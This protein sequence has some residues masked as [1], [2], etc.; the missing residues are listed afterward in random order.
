[1]REGAREPQSRH[2]RLRPGRDQTNALDRRDRVDDLLR[3]LEL[4]L[5][6]RAERR[7]GER[8]FSYRLDRL[9]IGVPENE[10]PPRLDPVDELASVGGAD[11]CA[12]P[13]DREERLLGPPPAPPAP[14]GGD[15]PP[16]QAERPGPQRR[17]RQNPEA[18]SFA[19]E[20]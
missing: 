17:P 9:G 19:P 11:V 10:R 5:G 13:A 20:L 2:G 8:S 6:R 1:M 15:A 18:E 4:A 16:G 14:P 7:A 12:F 3:E